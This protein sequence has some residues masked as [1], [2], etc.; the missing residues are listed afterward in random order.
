VQTLA[1]STLPGMRLTPSLDSILDFWRQQAAGDGPLRSFAQILVPQIDAH[2]ELAGPLD[3][4]V[5]QTHQSLVQALVSCIFPPSLQRMSFAALAT[6]ST[7][8]IHYATR[9]FREE[10]LDSE[11]QLRGEVFLEGMEWGY[12]RELFQYLQVARECYNRHFLFEKSVVLELCHGNLSRFF[13]FRAHFDHFQLR[14]PKKLPKLQESDWVQ[15]ASNLD[16]LELWRSLIPLEQFELYGLV[17]YEATNITEEVTLSAIKQELLAKDPL[18]RSETFARIQSRFQ[19]LLGVADL[20]VSVLASQDEQL[21]DLTPV[22]GQTLTLNDIRQTEV[23]QAF[24]QGCRDDLWAGKTFVIEDL[25]NAHLDSKIF[26]DAL[27]TGARSFLMMPLT[28]EDKFLGVLTCASQTAHSLNNL[29]PSRLREVTPLLS[30]AV[31]RTLEGLQH[32]VDAIIKERFTALHPAVEWKFRQQALEIIRSSQDL[33]ALSQDI[34]FADVYPLFGSSDV[35]NST[36]IRNQTIQQDLTRQLKLA[37]EILETAYRARPLSYLC[38]RRYRLNQWLHHLE[39]GL[40]SGDESRIA[41]FLRH[42]I[43]PLFLTVSRFSPQT[44]EQVTAYQ[45]A[46][47]PRLGTIYD[48]RRHY[49]HSMALIKECVASR[50]SARQQ[51][52]QAVFPHYFELHKSDGVDHTLY[53]GPSIHPAGAFDPL[54]LKNLRLWQ[55]ETMIEIARACQKITQDMTRVLGTAHLLL[56]QDQPLS[57]RFSQDEKQ[58]NVDG[59]YN[60][61]YEILKKRL[62]KAEV[63]HSGERLTQPG[64][65]AIVYSHPREASEYRDYIEYLQHRGEIEDEIEDLDIAPLQGVDGLRSLRIT[66][67]DQVVADFSKKV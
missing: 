28:L 41:E 2:P 67:R 56:V 21:I 36:V 8:D 7:F 20:Q 51:E 44:Q 23:C 35:R 53:V 11:G 42:D 17:V 12:L 30:L 61:R 65:V 63:R 57:I 5:L 6:P 52:A 3:P 10:L 39:G 62:D 37:S 55:L 54:Y 40:D 4:L 13:Q 33:D 50:L 47:D 29:T 9:R 66:V 14:A 1:V 49:E 15:L 58:F 32:R 34:L 59:A 43:E 48:Q 26:Q 25:A 38:S 16:N 24:C 18:A 45:E 22:A 60:A 46:I 31:R 19:A 27:A 64:K